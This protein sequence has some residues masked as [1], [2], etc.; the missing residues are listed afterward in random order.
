MD[1]DAARLRLPDGREVVFPRLGTGWDRATGENLWL[2]R[3]EPGYQVTNSSGMC[4]DL[5]ADGRR[6][7]FQQV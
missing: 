6:R 2:T 7:R 5:S 3:E 4:W 1:G